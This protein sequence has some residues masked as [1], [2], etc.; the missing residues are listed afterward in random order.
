MTDTVLRT[1]TDQ[2]VD[3]EILAIRNLIEQHA[4]QAEP[5]PMSKAK[6]I[7]K[8][9]P[10]LH[11]TRRNS[12]GPGPNAPLE[13]RSGPRAEERISGGAESPAKPHNPKEAQP[14]LPRVLLDKA[15]GKIKTYRPNRR[16]IVWTSVILL[17]L[18][19]PVAFVGWTLVAAIFLLAGYLMVGEDAFWR[20][21]IS[22][23]GRYARVSPEAARRLRV[24]ARLFAR[25][26]DRGLHWLP[27]R[28]ADSLRAPDVRSLVVADAR[29]EA[30]MLDRLRRLNTD[31]TA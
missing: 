17:L 31:R 23:H 22:M 2:S 24:Q 21:V 10:Q 28:M 16:A 26:W 4:V 18:L 6:A 9:A 5:A 20:G 12:S 14:S 19:H 7:V 3:A 8:P 1:K 30:A 27:D 11:D 13:E 15:I 29:H 25:R